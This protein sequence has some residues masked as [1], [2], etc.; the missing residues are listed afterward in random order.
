MRCAA[1]ELLCVS[2]N[3]N[4]PQLIYQE[5]TSTCVYRNRSPRLI[6]FLFF[7]LPLL[8]PRLIAGMPHHFNLNATYNR[9]QAIR[10]NRGLTCKCASIV[11]QSPN[12]QYSLNEWHTHF[13]ENVL[14]EEADGRRGVGAE[15]DE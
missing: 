13:T 2:T 9:G 11:F 6:S 7:F 12:I 5:R 14:A 3:F 4:P 15:G 1:A 10:P 8:L